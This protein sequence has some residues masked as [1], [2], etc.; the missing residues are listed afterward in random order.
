MASL[1]AGTDRLICDALGIGERKHLKRK[2][3]RLTSLGGEDALRLV[4]R[5]YHR[6]DGNFP[7]RPRS[8]SDQLWRP[9]PQTYICDRNQ[10][11]EKMLEKA[12][13]ILAEQGHM[14]GWSNQCPVATGISHSR[15]D[16]KRCVDLVHLSN[17][18]LRLVELKWIGGYTPA[19]ALFELLEYGLACLLARLHKREL[20]L[21]ANELMHDSIGN[22]RLEVV[23]PQAFFSRNERSDLF[24]AMDSAVTTF[25]NGRT[26]GQWTMSIQPLALPRNFN[27]IPFA[28]GLAVKRACA[29]RTLTPEGHMVREAFANLVPP[30]PIAAALRTDH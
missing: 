28:S 17:H 25:A 7:G 1:F 22:V 15:Q 27:A 8:S 30:S 24:S 23:G 21:G 26:N 19:Y 13:A 29:Q 9:T 4:Q 11:P 2:T 6:I 16:A 5:L 20:A 14:P 18:T 3:Q 12:V 10:S